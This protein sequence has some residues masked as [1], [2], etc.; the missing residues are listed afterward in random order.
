MI[1]LIACQLNTKICY[2]VLNCSN[3]IMPPDLLAAHGAFLDIELSAPKLYPSGMWQ[4]DAQILQ[5]GSRSIGVELTPYRIGLFRS[6]YQELVAWTRQVNL[7][8]VTGWH[9]VQRVHF[10]DSLM[11]SQALPVNVLSGGRLIDVGSGAGFPGL[12]LK[13]A[14]PD[15]HVSLVESVGKKARFLEHMVEV[16][17][18]KNVSIYADRAETLAH[19]QS[20]RE[21]YD[22]AVA[23][24]VASMPELLECTL[25]FC[26]VGGHVIAH[27]KGNI[28]RELD[29]SARALKVLGG[30]ILAVESV[31]TPGLLDERL[32]VV[33]EKTSL[34]PKKYPRQPGM[35]HKRPL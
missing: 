26:R 34:T 11:V 32:L 1:R 24:A 12:P 4:M 23:R 14:Y 6:Y 3:D 33:V 15:L 25:P 31:Y 22:I 16:L 35:P 19:C 7:T 20:I 18:M 28:S 5:E 10:L 30:R 8:S 2:F 27:K 9:E 29:Q 21:S 17:A 13:I